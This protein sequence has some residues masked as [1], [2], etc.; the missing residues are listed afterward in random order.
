[1]GLIPTTLHKMGT[2]KVEVHFTKRRVKEFGW[3][4][5]YRIELGRSSNEEYI[6]SGD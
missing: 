1:M 5:I 4:N 2:G 3:Q 6:R